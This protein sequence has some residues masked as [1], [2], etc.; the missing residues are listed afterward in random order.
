[1]APKSLPVA[2]LV[3]ASA[4]AEIPTQDQWLPVWMQASRQAEKA[5]ASLSDFTCMQDTYRATRSGKKRDRITSDSFQVEV[6]IINRREA[7]GWPGQEL[8]ADTPAELAAFG[9]FTTGELYHHLRKIVA[10]RIGIVR[11]VEFRPETEEWLFH[12]HSGSLSSGIIVGWPDGHK[13]DFQA[14]VIVN[15]RRCVRQLELFIPDAPVISRIRN[16]RLWLEYGCHWDEFDAIPVRST[17]LVEKWDGSQVTVD[18]RWHDCARFSATSQLVA[19]DRPLAPSAVPS[20]WLTVTTSKF[21]TELPQDLLLAKLTAGSSLQLVLKKPIQISNGRTLPSGTPV[22]ARVIGAN[23]V[24][25]IQKKMLAIRLE[26]HIADG[27]RVAFRAKSLHVQGQ[28]SRDSY[29]HQGPS[30]SR[31]AF[32]PSAATAPMVSEVVYTGTRTDA[33]VLVGAHDRHLPAGMVFDWET[34][35]AVEAGTGAQ[36]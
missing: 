8:K 33:M 18:S 2:I 34:L 28:A 25:G 30:F 31:Y 32:D 23:T 22:T 15:A 36:H 14:T 13:V 4:V 24:D 5:L 27:F 35:S 26:S 11:S 12:V 29:R 21:S 7:Y 17:A 20:Q 10:D 19:D 16:M 9:V 3:A 1:M 6:G